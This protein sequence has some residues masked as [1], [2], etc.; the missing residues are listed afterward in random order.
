LLAITPA[1]ALG[2]RQTPRADARFF[3]AT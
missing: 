3:L 2:V 1:L